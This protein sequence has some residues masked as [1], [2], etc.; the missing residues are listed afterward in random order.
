MASKKERLLKKR[1]ATAERREEAEFNKKRDEA[2]KI[3]KDLY[4]SKTEK[5]DA[6]LSKEEFS[7]KFAAS[8]NDLEK[9]G[10]SRKE[11]YKENLGETVFELN[12]QAFSKQELDSL[13][14]AIDRAR[15]EIKAG[16]FSGEGDATSWG[17]FMVETE[18]VDRDALRENYS[19]F[20]A[21]LKS[22]FGSKEEF[23]DWVS[24]TVEPTNI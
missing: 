18:G 6:I 15:A 13:T 9:M 17:N 23:E 16:V 3:Y 21:L 1:A 14:E 4:Y 7:A 19:T 10:Y 11:A 5:K 12:S 24:P 22:L 2:Y 8:R 20:Y